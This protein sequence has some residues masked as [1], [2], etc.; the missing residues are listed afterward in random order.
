MQDNLHPF[1]RMRSRMFGDAFCRP[2]DYLIRDYLGAPAPALVGGR[3]DIAMITREIATAVYLEYEL[4]ERNGGAAHV[5]PRLRSLT[6]I[7][8]L[9]PA[10]PADPG[11]GG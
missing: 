3:I 8:Q 7:R 9:A 1:E 4:T 10:P 11:I 6:G 5:R 2:R